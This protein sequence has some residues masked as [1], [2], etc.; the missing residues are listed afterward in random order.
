M[1]IFNKKSNPEN[2]NSITKR[3]LVYKAGLYQTP[4][5]KPVVK[6]TVSQ[7]DYWLKE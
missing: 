2:I 3:N 6:L 5:K 4:K 1:F 7:F